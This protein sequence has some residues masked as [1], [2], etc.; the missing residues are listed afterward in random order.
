MLRFRSNLSAFF[1]LFGH[2]VKINKALNTGDKDRNTRFQ[3]LE[4]TIIVRDPDVPEYEQRDISMG[5]RAG[6]DMKPL[7]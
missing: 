1:D 6:D 5:S 3:V 7:I 2:R 4:D